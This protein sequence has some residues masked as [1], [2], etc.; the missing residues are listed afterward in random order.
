[1]C[2]SVYL[3]KFT[4]NPK[5]NTLSVHGHSQVS[6]EGWQIWATRHTRSHGG[7]VRTLQLV[8]ALLLLMCILLMVCS[9][10]S[11]LSFCGLCRR[12]HFKTAP[13]VVRKR[14][15]VS[16][17]SRRQL[18]ALDRKYIYWTSFIQ[19]GI[20]VLLALSSTFM[21]QQ[22]ILN[23]LSWNRKTND[24][25]LCADQLMKALEP[26]GAA[27]QHLLI[28]CSTGLHSTVTKN[29]ATWLC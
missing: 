6:A 22:H 19:A 24:V 5:I 15:L 1:M 26:A 28:Q 21:N 4:C 10:P 25:R 20:I 12:F 14:W 13:T 16:P 9:V 3:L 29:K 18:H 17:S 8:S 2:E 27:V 11:F 23:N 7:W